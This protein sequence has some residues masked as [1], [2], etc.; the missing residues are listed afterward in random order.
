MNI[1][2]VF[3]C[4]MINFI[5]DYKWPIIII[6]ALFI[7]GI[8]CS[9]AGIKN[10]NEALLKH[11]FLS[12]CV[13]FALIAILFVFILLSFLVKILSAMIY[14]TVIENFLKIY[15]LLFSLIFCNERI[16][17]VSCQYVRLTIFVTARI[18]AAVDQIHFQFFVTE[19]IECDCRF[20]ILNKFLFTL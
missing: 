16:I 4:D 18:P 9:I 3:I 10:E 8:F 2:D 13:F 12:E 1:L 19:D 7:T 17:F 6:F 14:I 20:N 15:I 5:C 11:V